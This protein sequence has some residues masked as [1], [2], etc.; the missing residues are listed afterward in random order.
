MSIQIPAASRSDAAWDQFYYLTDH[1]ERN[2]HCGC[3][4]CDTWLG[5]T[6]LLLGLF[7]ESAPG[8]QSS[9]IPGPGWQL[10]RSTQGPEPRSE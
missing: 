5:V 3:P 8:S 10:E 6:A 1:V 4:S 2:P 7:G 9:G